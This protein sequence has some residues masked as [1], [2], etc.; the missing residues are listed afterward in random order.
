MSAKRPSYLAAAFSARPF[1]MPIP[2]NWLVL[3]A[4]GMLGWFLHPGWWCIGAG[5]EIGYL[6][7]LVRSTRFRAAI[8]GRQQ[9]EA[10][11][12]R[13]RLLKELPT[14]DQALQQGIESRCDDLLGHLARHGGD[15]GGGQ[16]EQLAQLCWLHLRLLTARHAL[17]SV[18]AARDDAD[19]VRR[20]RDVKR[21]LE[22]SD[23]DPAIRASLDGQLAVLEDRSRGHAQA[24]TRLQVVEAELERIRQE[25]EL[26]REQALLA[27][28]AAGITRSVDVL[29]GS[30]GQ[31]NRWMREQSD[32]FTELDPFADAPSPA[33]LFPAARPLSESSS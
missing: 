16:A 30:L 3:A 18:V 14:D 32:L 23:L 2:P 24:T 33:Q 4:F 9:P 31:A 25:V 21:R 19:L 7:T 8:D 28:D 17:R 6:A 29:A 11:D 12:R 27:T 1:G 26:A 20:S 15:G 22:K 5:L 10:S 13:G